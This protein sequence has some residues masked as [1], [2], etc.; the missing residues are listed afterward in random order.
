MSNPPLNVFGATDRGLVRRHN[1]DQIGWLHAFPA[2]H[3]GWRL[4]DA[5]LDQGLI[6]AISVDQI[7]RWGYLF[8]LADGVGG[9]RQGALASHQ[10]VQGLIDT[11]YTASI[12]ADTPVERLQVAL[13]QTNRS[14]AQRA[15]HDRSD[16][17]AT[18]VAALLYPDGS[19]YAGVLVNVGDSVGLL[20]EPQQTSELSQRHVAADGRLW[21]VMGD[22]IVEPSVCAFRLQRDAVL[23]LC[24]DGLTDTVARSHIAQLARSA[25]PRTAVKAL[26]CQAKRAGGHDN[27]SVLIVRPGGLQAVRYRRWLLSA[28]AAILALTFSWWAAKTPRQVAIVDGL[29]QAGTGA[30][31]ALALTSTLAPLPSATLQPALPTSTPERKVIH[32]PPTSAGVYLPPMPALTPT[33]V[34]PPVPTAVTALPLVS[35]TPRAVP[36]TS[37]PPTATSVA[38]LPTATA[39]VQA[40]PGMPAPSATALPLAPSPTEGA[41]QP[42]AV[43]ATR[44]VPPTAVSTAP[45]TSIP[46]PTPQPSPTAVPTAQPT[47]VAPTVEPTATPL[48]VEEPPLT[49]IP[50][51]AAPWPPTLV[52]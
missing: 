28:M 6:C 31:V 49:A 52:P 22:A 36:A 18:L 21:Q 19:E 46:V 40:E 34:L 30:Q 41:P 33:P 1:E 26:M 50:V 14:M 23:V 24:S 38:P 7:K 27:I 45:T 3:S 29:S 4:R 9:Q 42:S 39:P 2:L 10:A 11:F 25:Q 44:I 16:R 13:S 47:A 8:V 37:A 5:Q 43:A 20:C 15:A 32:P 51:T 35:A 17:A 12:V 48:P